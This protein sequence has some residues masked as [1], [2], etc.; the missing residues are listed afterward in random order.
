MKID[1][2]DWDRGNAE[3]NLHKH[4]I[5]CEQIEEIFHNSP[6]VAPDIKHSSTE[7]RFLAIGQISNRYAFVSFAIRLNGN[8]TL[9][10][11]ISARF[12]H[13]KEVKKYEEEIAED[14]HR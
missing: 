10:R 12:M 13:A 8:K 14:N 1:G 7:E 9:I 5:T 2:F 11:P 6:W 4:G 3:K